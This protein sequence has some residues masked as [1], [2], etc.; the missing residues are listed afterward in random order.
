MPSFLSI[1]DVITAPVTLGG[2]T[3]S[4]GPEAKENS[5]ICI[6]TTQH[7]YFC[8]SMSMVSCPVVL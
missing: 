3:L 5:L 1:Q 6:S 4:F 2:A 7:S 8:P